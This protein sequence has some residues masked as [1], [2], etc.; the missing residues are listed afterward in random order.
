M[1]GQVGRDG[2]PMGENWAEDEIPDYFPDRE[3]FFM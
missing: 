2:L 1:D 3:H